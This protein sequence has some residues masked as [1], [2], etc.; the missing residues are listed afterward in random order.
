MGSVS[1]VVGRPPCERNNY[2]R[3]HPRQC[4]H[5]AASGTAALVAVQLLPGDRLVCQMRLVMHV[6]PALAAGTRT[7]LS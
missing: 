4:A 7:R 6:G 1:R 5:T 2:Q 3:Q